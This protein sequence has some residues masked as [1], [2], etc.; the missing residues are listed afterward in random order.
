MLIFVVIFKGVPVGYVK[1]DSEQEA[2]I[3]AA[4]YGFNEYGEPPVVLELE[5]LD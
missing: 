3:V 1:A 2:R 4:S 5:E